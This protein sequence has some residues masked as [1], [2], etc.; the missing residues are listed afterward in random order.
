MP[1][2]GKKKTVDFFSPK[3]FPQCK[4]VHCWFILT[5]NEDDMNCR[6]THLNSANCPAPNVWIF[7]AHLVEHCSA[8]GE[9]MVSNPFQVPKLLFRLNLQ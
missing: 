4:K 2:S 5:W 7:I 6:N 3:R 1:G 8:N 9:A